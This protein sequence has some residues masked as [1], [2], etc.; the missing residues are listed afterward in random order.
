MIKLF[1]NYDNY[2]TYKQH[3]FDFS[4]VVVP[5]EEETPNSEL[6]RM[7]KLIFNVD[8]FGLPSNELT[9]YLGDKCSPEVSEFIR[10]NLLQSVSDS[11]IDTTGLSDDDINILS[12]GV[13][14]SRAQY[15]NRLNSYMRSQMS[16]VKARAAR[17]KLFKSL[18]GQ[19]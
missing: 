9:L 14:E 6:E 17:D 12:R 1:L 16:A 18:E 19:K 11:N 8:D 3:D 7:Q 13:N 2:R 10:K 5:E 4:N 15:V